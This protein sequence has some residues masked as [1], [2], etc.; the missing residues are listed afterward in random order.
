M[1]K[2]CCSRASDCPQRVEPNNDSVSSLLGFLGLAAAQSSD[3]VCAEGEGPPHR[4]CFARQDEIT[5]ITGGKRTPAIPSRS[6]GKPQEGGTRSAA[7]F[8]YQS[9][10]VILSSRVWRL[11]EVDSAMRGWL[12]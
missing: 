12:L 10:Q 4:C 6:Q 11:N 1:V 8:D 5:T 7:K 3:T 9:T 2:T